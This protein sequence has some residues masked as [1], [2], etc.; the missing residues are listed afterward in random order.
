MFWVKPHHD[1]VFA[2]NILQRFRQT[3][4]GQLCMTD[5]ASWL[6]ALLPQ[7]MQRV[8]DG[9]SSKERDSR[10]ARIGTNLSSVQ[11]CPVILFILFLNKHV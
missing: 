5:P 6:P 4:A 1:E 3:E 11:V 8:Q 9:R 7:T 10:N 2:K